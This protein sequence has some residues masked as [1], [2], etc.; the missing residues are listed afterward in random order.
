MNNYIN[1]AENKTENFEKSGLFAFFTEEEGKKAER[2]HKSFPE[3]AATPLVKLACLSEKLGLGGFYLKDE[4]FRFGLNAFKVLGGSYAIGNYIADRLGKDISEINCE[5]ITGKDVKERL[6]DLTFITATDG[7]HGRGVAWTANRIGQKS[8][9]YM[10]KGT[11]GERL[12]NI[13]K[14]GSNASILDLVYDDCVRLAGKTATE[15]QMP[16]IQDTVF[17]GNEKTPL[18]V[19]QGYMTMA[20]EAIRQLGD[21]VPTHVFLQAGVG[22]MAAAVAAYLTNYYGKDKPVIIIVEPHSADCLYKTARLGRITA[23][24]GE[25]NS[26][27]AGLCC[28][29]PCPPAWELLSNTAEYFITIPDGSAAVGMRTLAHPTGTDTKVVSGESGASATGALI[30]IMTRSDCENIRK[31]LGL[32]ENSVVLCFSTEGDTDKENYRK[33]T[34]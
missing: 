16:M 8:I 1:I 27:M 7:N 21:T 26:M 6:G 15:M 19:M 31:I 3:Y 13:K 10:P 32:N 18:H 17:G 34:E 9:V 30:D 11:A 24:D 12:E 23:C 33:I 2:Y 29:E 4:S 20:R 25:M 22:S 5:Y 28:G 14:L